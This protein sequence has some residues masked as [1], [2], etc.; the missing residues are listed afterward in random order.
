MRYAVRHIG[1]IPLE[2]PASTLTTLYP[3]PRL[4]L[5]RKQM[6]PPR[7]KRLYQFTFIC[8]RTRTFSYHYL[9]KKHLLR[10]V[11]RTTPLFLEISRCVLGHEWWARSHAGPLWPTN[12]RSE[13]RC[14][15]TQVN[16]KP[17]S[18]SAAHINT[19]ARA[20]EHQLSR[21]ACALEL[22]GQLYAIECTRCWRV[23]LDCLS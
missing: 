7:S 2:N 11:R 16:A 6:T 19:P 4:T 18:H 5:E 3:Q 13:S 21:Q 20:S 1:Q 22:R 15:L 10:K 17:A 9:S 14:C 8:T 23:S 12:G